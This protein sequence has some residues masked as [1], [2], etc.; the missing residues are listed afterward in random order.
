MDATKQTVLTDDC[1]PFSKLFVS[2]KSRECD[3]YDFFRH[4]NHPFPAAL[5]DGGKLHAC[6]KSQL[7]AVLESH[8]TLP[9]NEP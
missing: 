7:A 9:D 4:E 5:S 3:L 2:Y 1:Q 6:Q 8:A